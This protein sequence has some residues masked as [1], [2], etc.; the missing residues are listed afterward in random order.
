MSVIFDSGDTSVPVQ[1]TYHSAE[2]MNGT[3]GVICQP[4]A[5]RFGIDDFATETRFKCGHF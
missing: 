2:E 3:T 1:I 4:A 5:C